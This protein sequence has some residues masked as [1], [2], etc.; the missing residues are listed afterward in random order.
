MRQEEEEEEEQEWANEWRRRTGRDENSARTR[1]AMGGERTSEPV[2]VR[3][4]AAMEESV[5]VER[6]KGGFCGATPVRSDSR[7]VPSTLCGEVLR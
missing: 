5:R 2:N 3:E 7:R 6:R 1:D 4:D